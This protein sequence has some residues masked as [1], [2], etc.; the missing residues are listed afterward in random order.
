MATVTFMD[1][2]ALKLSPIGSLMPIS[3]Y[4]YRFDQAYDTFAFAPDVLPISLALSEETVYQMSL[5]DRALGNLNA[6][7]KFLP[8]PTVLVRPALMSEAK[9][10]S[11]I[12][13]TFATL[14][15]ILTADYVDAKRPSEMRE[16]RNYVTAALRSVQLIETLPICRRV[17]EELHFILVTGTR[18]D[19]SDAGALRN[20]Q[21]FIGAEEA[22]VG[23]ARFIPVPNGPT[24][25]EGFSQ[26]ER[27]VNADHRLPLLAK[28]ALTHYQFETLHPFSDGNGRLGRLIITLQLMAAGELEHPILN[29]SAWFQPRKN[30]YIDALMHVSVTGDFNS[31]ITMFCQA[32]TDRAGSSL[33]TIDALFSYRDGIVERAALLGMRSIGQQ[34]AD[35]VIGQPV[36]TVEELR[37]ALGV[38]TNTAARRARELEELN[39][40]TEVTGSTYGRVYLSYPVVQLLEG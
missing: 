39:V 31:W 22:K 10:T 25:E 2:E 9:A 8:N 29:L 36:F 12:E 40:V 33:A 15:E 20:K 30:Q 4:D 7:I 26:W 16:I 32:V 17:I 14:D 1:I 18:G 6:R 38:S 37:V 11:A 24:L 21:V 19:G 28:V 23:D 35:F 5:A 27:W 13:G 34:I 3:G